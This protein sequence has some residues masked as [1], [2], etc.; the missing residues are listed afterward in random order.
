MVTKDNLRAEVRKFANRKPKRVCA[1]CGKSK[2]QVF[3]LE[4]WDGELVCNECLENDIEF[5]KLRYLGARKAIIFLV[6]TGC[7]RDKLHAVCSNLW[8]QINDY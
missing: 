1:R 6:Q 8:R 2:K 5:W 3:S 7:D 4:G